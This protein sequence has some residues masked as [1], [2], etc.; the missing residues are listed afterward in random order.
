MCANQDRNAMW[1]YRV[2]RQQRASEFS[3]FHLPTFALPYYVYLRS[4]NMP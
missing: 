3:A 1:L 2:K 4:Q